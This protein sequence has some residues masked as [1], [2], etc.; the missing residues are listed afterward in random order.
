MTLEQQTVGDAE[1]RRFDYDDATTFVA[2]LGDGAE[3]DVVG[4]T[5][6]VV[7]DDGQYDLSLPENQG[8]TA[9]MK[10]GVLTIEVDQ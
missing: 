5:A 2:D 9:F 4:N 3:I 6:I 8:A 10:N 1:I 7:T